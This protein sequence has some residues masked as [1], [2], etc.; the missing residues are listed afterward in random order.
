MYYFSTLPLYRGTFLDT[1]RRI[2]SCGRQNL[3]LALMKDLYK[4]HLQFQQTINLHYVVGIMP[5][6]QSL[7]YHFLSI[8]LDF[9]LRRSAKSRSCQEKFWSLFYIS[10][11]FFST[12]FIKIVI[13]RHIHFLT[14][15]VFS[16]VYKSHFQNFQ[17]QFKKTTTI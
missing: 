10:G 3:M 2:I 16:F 1:H 6:K 8:N 17:L 14:N 13:Y 5:K 11:I 12:K 7:L 15:A 4:N 9:K